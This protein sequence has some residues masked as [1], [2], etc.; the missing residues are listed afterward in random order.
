M[1]IITILRKT[2]IIRWITRRIFLKPIWP[3]RTKPSIS[4]KRTL[5]PK[6]INTT[7]ITKKWQTNHS[8]TASKLP[9]SPKASSKRYLPP[10]SP[11]KKTK[12]PVKSQISTSISALFPSEAKRKSQTPDILL[13]KMSTSNKD[14]SP[15][16][17]PRVQP[18]YRPGIG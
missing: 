14:S 13:N 8:K 5:L 6:M 2:S 1:R 4:K 7:P 10:I 15:N 3:T 17:V 12:R 11:N 18:K 9:R 16:M